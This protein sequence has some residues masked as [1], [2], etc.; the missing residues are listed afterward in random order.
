MCRQSPRLTLQEGVTKRS[1]CANDNVR[2]IVFAYQEVEAVFAL[3]S[4]QEPTAA[5]LKASVRAL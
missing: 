5:Q 1:L 3:S 2:A 4:Y